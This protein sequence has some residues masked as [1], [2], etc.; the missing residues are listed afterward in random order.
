MA[1]HS[2]ELTTRFRFETPA[3][4]F[5]RARLSAEELELAGW[6]GVRRY[7][8]KIHRADI[9]HVDVLPP[10]GLV[11]WLQDG[12]TIRLSVP[13]PQNWERALRLTK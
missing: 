11:L 12:Q 4:W 7:R 9:V 13:E 5:A 10:N 2:S 1:S 6:Q 8:R 3:L